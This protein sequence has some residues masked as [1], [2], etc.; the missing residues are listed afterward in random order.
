MLKGKRYLAKAPKSPNVLGAGSAN[1]RVFV[2][3][4]TRAKKK[5][6]LENLPNAPFGVCNYDQDTLKRLR[7]GNYNFTLFAARGVRFDFLQ[8][9]KRQNLIFG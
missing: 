9:A 2:M 6:L 4:P 5:K 3:T 1:G 7:G 8:T